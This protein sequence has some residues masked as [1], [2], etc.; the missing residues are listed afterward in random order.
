[1]GPGV[2]TGVQNLCQSPVVGQGQ[3]GVGAG[4]MAQKADALDVAI[5]AV[6]AVRA[7]VGIS[8]VVE[9]RGRHVMPPA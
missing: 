5:V 7:R 2:G 6:D 1:M 3:A 8:H 9:A 4:K